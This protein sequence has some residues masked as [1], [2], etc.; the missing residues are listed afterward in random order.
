VC[1]GSGVGVGGCVGVGAG[2]GA[3]VGVGVGV[4]RGL[5]RGVGVGVG[6]GWGAG[7]LAAATL[8]EGLGE[9]DGL[10]LAAGD[11]ARDVDAS[12]CQTAHA[13]SPQYAVWARA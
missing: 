8:V 1:V 10:E 12:E 13:T 6:A 9:R 5:R 7:G 11:G 2:V 4:G 3:G